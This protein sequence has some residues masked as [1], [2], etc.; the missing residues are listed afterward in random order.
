MSAKRGITL[1]AS[2]G[3]RPKALLV[4]KPLELAD[5]D[6]IRVKTAQTSKLGLHAIQATLKPCGIGHRFGNVDFASVVRVGLALGHCVSLLYHVRLCRRDQPLPPRR[7]FSNAR[8]TASDCAR[9]SVFSLVPGVSLGPKY[10]SGSDF[11]SRKRLSKFSFARTRS[12]SSLA[13]SKSLRQAI[14]LS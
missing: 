2:S 9:P 4:I 6:D 7:A 8:S 3:K 12:L 10:L 14:V 11:N 5:D 13:L 1:S